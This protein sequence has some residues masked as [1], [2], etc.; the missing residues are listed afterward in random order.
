MA[1]DLGKIVESRAPAEEIA[2]TIRGDEEGGR[3]A[4]PARPS[5]RSSSTIASS[6]RSGKART[7]WLPVYPAPPV[8]NAAMQ[9]SDCR[10]YRWHDETASLRS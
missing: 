1:D 4:G 5:E 10:P 9:I 6:P 8:A 3:I 2:D 7:A